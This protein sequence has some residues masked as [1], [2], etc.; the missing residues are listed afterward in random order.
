MVDLDGSPSLHQYLA[1]AGSLLLIGGMIAFLGIITAEVLFP[2]YSTSENQISDLGTSAE[3]LDDTIPPPSAL[4]FDGAMVLV[5]LMTLGA[6]VCLHRTFED[7]V[8]TIP[9]SLL[10]IGLTGV[11]IFNGSFGTIHALFALLIFIA[12]G[13]SAIAAARVERSPLCY[14]SVILGA[15]SLINLVSFLVLGMSGPLA[16]LGPG[17]MERWVVYPVL[18]WLLVFG[19]YLFGQS[20]PA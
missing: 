10:G 11:G 14:I 16:F 13:L 4:I 1:I 7:L 15:V 17:G 12:G 20:H 8:V 9:L 19:G 18:L 3:S 6:S 2:G 5:G